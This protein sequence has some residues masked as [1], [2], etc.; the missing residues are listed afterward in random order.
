MV[1]HPTLC[2]KCERV[3]VPRATLPRPPSVC[4]A[5]KHDLSALAP[6]LFALALLAH[7]HAFL[8]EDL[9][10]YFGDFKRSKYFDLYVRHK[11]MEIETVHEDDFHQFRV[12][13]VGGF[14]SVNAAI[15]KARCGCLSLPASH[16]KR[17]QRWMHRTCSV[18]LQR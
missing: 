3:S 12:L 10:D 4:L 9:S 2:L 15:K 16:R 13:G 5:H 6:F 17:R 7:R 18:P 11:S 1:S 8:K 14:G